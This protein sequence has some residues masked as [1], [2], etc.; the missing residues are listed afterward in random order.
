M[1]QCAKLR[2]CG[3]P[4]YCV[5]MFALIDLTQVEKFLVDQRGE[6]APS[7]RDFWWNIHGSA[8]SRRTYESV[9][10][11][12]LIIL[13]LKASWIHLLS[14]QLYHVRIRELNRR[15]KHIPLGHP[16]FRLV[17]SSIYSLS[18]TI[19]INKFCETDHDIPY[20]SL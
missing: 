16:L 19:S 7:R 13:L 15:S 10:Q 3:N 18:L 6:I 20:I 4:Y 12:Y 14:K 2:D 8:K 1:L 17:K 9:T 11:M 5:T